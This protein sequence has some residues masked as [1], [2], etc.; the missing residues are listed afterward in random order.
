VPEP[1]N[2]QALNR[3]AYAL[4]NPLKYIDPSGHV[5]IC[6]IGCDDNNWSK[7]SI[8]WL[9]YLALYGVRLVGNW[10][11]RNILVAVVAVGDSGQKLRASLGGTAAEAYSSVFGTSSSDPMVLFW[12]N[13]QT[14]E[15]T[16]MGRYLS[17]ECAGITAGG[18]AS[19]SRLINF[20]SLSEQIGK[21][22]ARQAHVSARNNIVHELGHAFANRFRANGPYQAMGLSENRYLVG[23]EGFHPSP[24]TAQ[25][26]WRQHPGD[27]PNE[28]FADMFLGWV[29]GMWADDRRGRARDYFMTVNMAEWVPRAAGR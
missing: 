1:G 5:Y 2:P 24:I 29:Y 13:T 28:A 25:R 14:D 19:S 18:C 9:A 7:G 22:T 6:A 16:K 8:D 27:S 20:M 12:G 15:L 21:R 11:A 4:N 26:T 3:Y 17:S 10:T 23:D